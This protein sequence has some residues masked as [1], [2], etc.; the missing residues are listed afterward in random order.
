MIRTPLKEQTNIHTIL[1]KIN[2]RYIV[3]LPARAISLWQPASCSNFAMSSSMYE[4]VL[5]IGIL[6]SRGEKSVCRNR[7]WMDQL[8]QPQYYG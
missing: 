3:L 1:G 8:D 2:Y 7:E 4:F 5:A 6:D